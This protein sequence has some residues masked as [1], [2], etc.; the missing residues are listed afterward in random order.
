VRLLPCCPTA[1]SGRHRPQE[2]SFAEAPLPR[3][4]P[5]LNAWRPRQNED[6]LLGAQQRDAPKEEEEAGPQDEREEDK[7]K[8]VE[9]EDDFEGAL[10]VRA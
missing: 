3:A 1:S 4:T 10:E 7:S 2:R 5:T 8:G 9:M 6:Q